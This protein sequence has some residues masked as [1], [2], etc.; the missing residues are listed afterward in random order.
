MERPVKLWVLEE[1]QVVGATEESKLETRFG[2][3]D[4]ECVV[5]EGAHVP[6]GSSV[7]FVDVNTPP[8][9]RHPPSPPHDVCLFQIKIFFHPPVLDS[10]VFSS[11]SDNERNMNSLLHSS[12]RIHIGEGGIPDLIAFSKSPGYKVQECVVDSEDSHPYPLHIARGDL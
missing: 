9:T 2:E 12:W 6:S 4:H 11:V 3:S 10:Q 7:V 8:P 1:R 5:R